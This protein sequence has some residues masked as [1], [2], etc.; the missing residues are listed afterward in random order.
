M[1][2][3][4]SESIKELACALAKAQ[5][6]MGGAHK[7]KANPFFKSV[8]ADLSSVVTAI[9]EPLSSNGLS[10]IQAT[11]PSDKD[12][13]RVIT[14]LMHESGEWL[15]ST[16]AIPVSKADAQGYGSAITYAKRYGLQGLLGV[17]SEDDDGNAAAKAKPAITPVRAAMQSV[18][19]NT[20]DMDFLRGVASELVQMVEVEADPVRAFD[21]MSKQNLDSDQKLALWSILQPNSKTRSAI[22]KEGEARKTEA[23]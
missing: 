21:H 20:E 13:I 2:M 18:D 23:A 14:M 10:F 15:S 12:E 16:I 4:K 19:I 11:E 22:K 9:R 5:G 17:P 8:Y 1:I 3:N 7:G 6:Q